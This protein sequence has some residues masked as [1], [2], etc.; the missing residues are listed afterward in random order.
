MTSW[1]VISKNNY[2]V[3][4]QATTPPAY[5]GSKVDQFAVN[6]GLQ[7]DTW[8]CRVCLYENV[9]AGGFA[10][11]QDTY[12]GDDDRYVISFKA[13]RQSVFSKNWYGEC[14]SKCENCNSEF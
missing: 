14:K 5:S 9:C 8:K 12:N 6:H 4:I 3:L 13:F 2:E 7:K 1:K 10:C 11:E